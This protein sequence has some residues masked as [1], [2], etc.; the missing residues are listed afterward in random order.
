MTST[1]E[2][3]FKS[4]NRTLNYF[5]NYSETFMSFLFG[6]IYHISFSDFH[7]LIAKHLTKYSLEVLCPAGARVTS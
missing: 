3:S 4:S 5:R 1:F 7:S 2:R 6:Q